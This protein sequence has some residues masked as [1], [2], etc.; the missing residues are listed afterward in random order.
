MIKQSSVRDVG[1]VTFSLSRKWM[2]QSIHKMIKDGIDTW[3]PKL[4]VERVYVDFPSLDEDLH[5]GLLRRQTIRRTLILMLRYS[6]VAVL[7]EGNFDGR[8]FQ[9]HDILK[10]WFY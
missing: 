2:A 5:V 4:P 6:K 8:D 7:S 10:R 1:Y 9:G 3:A